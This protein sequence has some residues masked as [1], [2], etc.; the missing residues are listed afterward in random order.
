MVL[1]GFTNPQVE[2]GVILSGFTL[3]MVGVHFLG[4]GLTE[5]AGT[6]INVYIVYHSITYTS[7]FSV[8]NISFWWTIGK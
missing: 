2:I 8:S 7:N 6:K 4:D 1:T 3:F 5:L